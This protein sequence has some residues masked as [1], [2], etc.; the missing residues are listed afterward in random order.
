VRCGG[1]HF[2]RAEGTV[3]TTDFHAR[4]L[5]ETVWPRSDLADGI[6]RL[7][8]LHRLREVLTLAVS[9]ASKP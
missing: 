6:E 3:S 7:V 1:V 2:E 4:G 8:Q 9:P 5:P